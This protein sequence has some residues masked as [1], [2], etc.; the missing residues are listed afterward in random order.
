MHMIRVK[1]GVGIVEYRY[2]DQ[3]A[4]ESGD[5]KLNASNVEP[6]TPSN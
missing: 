3:A 5:L 1:L 2:S 4:E 6:E